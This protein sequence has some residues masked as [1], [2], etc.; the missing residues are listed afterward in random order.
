MFGEVEDLFAVSST[1]ISPTQHQSTAGRE[2]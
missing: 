2:R 1:S